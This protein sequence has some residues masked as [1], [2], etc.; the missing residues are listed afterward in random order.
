MR[1]IALEQGFGRVRGVLQ[2]VV[3]LR[4]LARLDLG[5]FGADGNHGVAKT[6]QLLQRFALGG[7]DHQRAGDREAQCRRMKAIVDQTLG[8]VFGADALG[9]AGAVLQRPQIENALVRHAAALDPGDVAAVVHLVVVSQARS[10]VVG[11]QDRGLGR[12]LQSLGAH[13][14]HVHPADRQHRG[15]T[16]RCCA[17]GAHLFVCSQVRRC[18]VPAGKAPDPPPRTPGRHPGRRRRAECRR[19]CAG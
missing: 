9:S 1:P 10:D 3:G 14:A 16:Q 5:D 6:V 17:D 13:H 7:F 12:R 18:D 2:R 4:P 8:H 15:V 11:R 19:S